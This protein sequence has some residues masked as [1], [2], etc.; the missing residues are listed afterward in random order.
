M[1]IE[2]IFLGAAAVA[3]FVV[4]GLVLRNILNRSSSESTDEIEFFDNETGC[5][6]KRICNCDKLGKCYCGNKCEC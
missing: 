5:K 2:L 6:C 3:I 1:K 4:I